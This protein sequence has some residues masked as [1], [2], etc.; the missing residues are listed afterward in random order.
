MTSQDSTGI[1]YRALSSVTSGW[2]LYKCKCL[3]SIVPPLGAPLA[4]FWPIKLSKMQG[5]KYLA[6]ESRKCVLLSLMDS[7]GLEISVLWQSIPFKGCALLTI[8]SLDAFFFK[9]ICRS[10]ITGYVGKFWQNWAGRFASFEDRKDCGRS[11]FQRLQAVR[12]RPVSRLKMGPVSK[13][14]QLQDRKTVN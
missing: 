14:R 13:L 10:A 11:K 5:G 8:P 6:H 1:E 3:Y 12:P 4:F 7:V 9:G 2:I